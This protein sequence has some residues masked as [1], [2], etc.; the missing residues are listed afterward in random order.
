MEASGM[1]RQAPGELAHS[2]VCDPA[3][4]L[5]G[6]LRCE[7][8]GGRLAGLGL[9]AWQP[10]YRDRRAAL[11]GTTGQALSAACPRDGWQLLPGGPCNETGDLLRRGSSCQNQAEVWNCVLA[12]Q[13]T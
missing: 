3:S 1:L 6:S 10:G 9:A 2:R 5:L 7:G 8:S 11:L 12:M 13:V 4:W